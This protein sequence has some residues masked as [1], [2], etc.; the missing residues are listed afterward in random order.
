MPSFRWRPVQVLLAS[1][2]MSVDDTRAK[3]SPLPGSRR[4]LIGEYV[5]L[6][7]EASVLELADAFGVSPD[8]VRRDL[9][10]LSASG[11][12][13]RIHGGAVA[14]Q[15]PTAALMTPTERRD[16]RFE[17]KKRIGAIAAGLLNDGETVLMNGGTTVLEVARALSGRRELTLITCS[18]AVLRETPDKS[19]RG[20]YL[21]G[22]RW[23]PELEVV[24]GPVALPGT[25]GIT[26]D[27]LV[28]GAAALAAGSGVSIPLADEAE[29]LQSMIDAAKRR[30]LVADSSKFGLE[31]LARI[32]AFEDIDTLVTDEQPPPEL[33]H[34]L[35]QAGVD[36]VVA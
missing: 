29:M 22:G 1:W 31:A 6:N 9:M 18:P 10:R 8:T 34:A 13:A 21:L 4:A 33:L 25:R 16:S 30:I 14:A 27:V 3:Q 28:L 26:A 7:G 24:V 35:E 32:A 36:V 15:R 5:N 17:A 12:I 20:A 19:L 2:L 11:A 23:Y